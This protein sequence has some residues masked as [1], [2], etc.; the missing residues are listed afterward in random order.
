MKT[1]L[2]K[3]FYASTSL[4]GENDSRALRSGSWTAARIL[5]L[6]RCQQNDTQATTSFSKSLSKNSFGIPSSSVPESRRKPRYDTGTSLGWIQQIVWSLKART[7][8]PADVPTD[9][10]KTVFVLIVLQES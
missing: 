6:R 5:A 7:S 8:D 2:W 3:C 4:I 10:L 1:P 9:C